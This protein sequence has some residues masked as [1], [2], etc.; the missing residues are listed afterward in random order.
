MIPEKNPTGLEKKVTRSNWYIV[1]CLKLGPYFIK[2]DIE[3]LHFKKSETSCALKTYYINNHRC[4]DVNNNSF[5]NKIHPMYYSNNSTGCNFIIKRNILNVRRLWLY[6]IDSVG[7]ILTPCQ[8]FSHIRN[9]VNDFKNISF[10][11]K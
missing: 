10:E 2:I 4:P 7:V 3:F 5:N 6:R 9:R 11:W 1:F 8:I